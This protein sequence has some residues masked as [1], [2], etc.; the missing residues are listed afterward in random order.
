MNS[1]GEKARV[2]NLVFAAVLGDL[3]RVRSYFSDTARGQAEYHQR[4]EI[5]ERLRSL[6]DNPSG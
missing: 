1:F 6:L 3:G 5:A 4:R 2:D